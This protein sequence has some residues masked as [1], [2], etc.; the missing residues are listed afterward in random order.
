[1]CKEI[2]GA[3]LKHVCNV[4]G[5]TN[6]GLTTQEVIDKMASYAFEFD[7]EIPVFDTK[8]SKSKNKRTILFEDLSKFRSE[9]QFYIIQEL[10]K[11]P[12][13][14]DNQT[15]RFLELKLYEKY[16]YLSKIKSE[17]SDLNLNNDGFLNKYPDV[18]KIYN[19]G[20][21]AYRTKNYK[22]SALDNMR[23]ALEM[24][25]KNILKNS[26][27]IENQQDYLGEYIKKH[28]ISKEISNMLFKLINYYSK[29]QNNYVKHANSADDINIEEAEFI[30]DLTIVIIGF[31]I[32]LEK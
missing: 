7:V 6:N 5:D 28:N 2:D 22:R 29:F 16:G 9:E 12:K 21:D 32:K 14:D 20:L 26:E 1:M 31:L 15:V 23:L 8:T 24:L 25:L 11:L 18:A 30:I 3:F 10:M 13:F 27:S 17:I 4:L 19:Q